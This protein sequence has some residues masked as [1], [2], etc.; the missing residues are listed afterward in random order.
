MSSFEGVTLVCQSSYVKKLFELSSLNVLAGINMSL[1]SFTAE[2]LVAHHV[3][4]V[5]SSSFSMCAH[6]QTSNWWF[7]NSVRHSAL[8]C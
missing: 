3:S 4:W 8:R 1:L 2:C 5:E 6:R 7:I